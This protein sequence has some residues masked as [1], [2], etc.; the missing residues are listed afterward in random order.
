[1][2]LVDMG[3]M[4]IRERGIKGCGGWGLSGF[5]LASDDHCVEWPCTPS[6]TPIVQ[7]RLFLAVQLY[8]AHFLMSRQV[9]FLAGMA[10]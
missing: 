8:S 5:Q 4:L 3:T 2:G 7:N 6:S 1:M 10:C 9:F